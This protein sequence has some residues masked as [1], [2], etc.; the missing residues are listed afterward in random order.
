MT[1]TELGCMGVKP[2]LDIMDPSKPEGRILP[3]AWDI[4]TTKPG[5]PS[6]VVWG[7]EHEEPSRVWAFFDWD[8][9][10]QHNEFVK[11]FA[12]DAV[13]DI[14]TICTPDEIRK[15]AALEPSTDALTAP[16]V[17]VTLAY[18]AGDISQD[19][20]DV[21]SAQIERVLAASG[22]NNRALGWSVENDFPIR[23]EKVKTGAA[24]MGVVGW[25]SREEQAK[26]RETGAY[27]ESV[28]LL[29]RTPG[30]VGSL[31][32]SIEGKYKDRQVD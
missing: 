26:F 2:N 5:G 30:L 20:K 4:V 32:V 6:R 25:P 18:F 15:H 23:G 13:K 28:E 21:A 19:D 29:K 8:S 9:V 22:I 24:L 14:P 16:W 3:D 12:P 10:E 17:E 31:S 11:T 7:L 27:K 1:I